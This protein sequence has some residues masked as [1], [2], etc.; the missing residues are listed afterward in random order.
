MFSRNI[1]KL[2]HFDVPCLEVWNLIDPIFKL[3]WYLTCAS[4]DRLIFETILSMA[5]YG[6]VLN[7]DTIPMTHR[8]F[9]D[10][11]TIFHCLCAPTDLLLKRLSKLLKKHT[12]SPHFFATKLT[13]LFSKLS[14][15]PLPVSGANSGDNNNRRN[16]ICNGYAGARP[17][18]S[19]F[20]F[21]RP[22]GSGLDE[23]AAGVQLRRRLEN[24]AVCQNFTFFALFLPWTEV[25]RPDRDFSSFTLVS[26][27]QD[28]WDLNF[29]WF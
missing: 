6:K 7:H 20:R 19:S 13:S 23:D 12:F 29:A 28:C 16:S 21:R 14:V 11:F 4:I 18:S 9:L 3:P 26:F 8:K 10:V 22:S 25:C 1:A 15:S 24:E 17:R 5:F 2:P 27:F